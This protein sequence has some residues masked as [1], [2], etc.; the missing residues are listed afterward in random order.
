M[1]INRVYLD[2]EDKGICKK[3]KGSRI[4]KGNYIRYLVKNNVPDISHRC[5]NEND[6]IQVLRKLKKYNLTSKW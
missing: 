3:K 5:L 2:F 4:E 1:N 6:L